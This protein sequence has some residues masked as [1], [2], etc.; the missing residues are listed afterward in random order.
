M[1]EEADHARSASPIFQASVN[2]FD[3]QRGVAEIDKYFLKAAVTQIDRRR[4]AAE[5]GILPPPC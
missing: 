4:I 5:L 1:F 2:S 3:T